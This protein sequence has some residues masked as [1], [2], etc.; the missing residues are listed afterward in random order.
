M[1]GSRSLAVV[2]TGDG[3][4]VGGCGIRDTFPDMD[5]SLTDRLV[6][7][8]VSALSGADLLA[9]L[10]AVQQHQRNLQKAQLALLEENQEA[11]AR[12]PELQQELERLQAL[13][14]DE[15]AAQGS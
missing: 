11:I 15:I 6:N 14:P 8:D 3:S 13:P 5:Q 4:A 10:D 2:S 9:H 1:P 7:T 12:Y